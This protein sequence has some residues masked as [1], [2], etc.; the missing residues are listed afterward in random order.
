MIDS[1]Q[2]MKNVTWYAQNVKV[3]NEKKR[4]KY[5]NQLSSQS[6]INTPETHPDTSA[7]KTFVFFLCRVFLVSKGT[8]LLCNESYVALVFINEP[9][10]DFMKHL[11]MSKLRRISSANSTV[12]RSFR[13]D[14]LYTSDGPCI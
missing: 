10:S 6:D 5:K 4:F 7:I 1:F 12:L 3:R 9:H 8:Y 13:K 14:F 2:L 11:S